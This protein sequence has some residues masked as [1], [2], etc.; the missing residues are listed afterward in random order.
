MAFNDDLRLSLERNQRDLFNRIMNPILERVRCVAIARVGCQLSHDVVQDVIVVI[1]SKLTSQ[2]FA[3]DNQL[4]RWSMRITRFVCLRTI[5]AKPKE[6]YSE[7]LDYCDPLTKSNNESMSL[8]D[9]EI[10]RLAMQS[11][12]EDE[13]E[14]VIRKYFEGQKYRELAIEFE[15]TEEN[16]RR[17]MSQIRKQLCDFLKA[18]FPTWFRLNK[19]F[20]DGERI[21]STLQ[22]G[23]DH[24]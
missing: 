17:R 24:E 22:T 2:H 15:I 3:N 19:A 9:I 8:E 18:N 21:L 10:I 20:P 1:L 13:R 23:C 11:L 14:M 4:M 5:A 6:V 12:D 7:L 16:A